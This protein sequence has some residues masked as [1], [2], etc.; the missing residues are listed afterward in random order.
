MRLVFKENYMRIIEK[1]ALSLLLPTLMMVNVSGA[2]TSTTTKAEPATTEE[3][4]KAEPATT[5]ET[6]KEELKLNCGI[7]P[8]C[9]P[10]RTECCT[11][12]A[13]QEKPSTK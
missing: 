5:E 12:E 1:V 10:D 3:T 7:P 11:K 8:A 4:T 9:P 13:P 6:K 2:E